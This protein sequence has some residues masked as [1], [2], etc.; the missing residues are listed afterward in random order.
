MYIYKTT[1]VKR[2]IPYSSKFSWHNIFVNFVIWLLIT[3]IF[4]TKI[5]YFHCGRGNVYAHAHHDCSIHALIRTRS[6]SVERCLKLCMPTFKKT[7][8]RCLSDPQEPLSKQLPSSLIESANNNVQVQFSLLS[9]ECEE[10][11]SSFEYQNTYSS[12]LSYSF[13]KRRRLLAFHHGLGARRM[14]L[15]IAHSLS[16]PFAVT[17]VVLLP[18]VEGVR[19]ILPWK[20]CILQTIGVIQCTPHC[21]SSIVI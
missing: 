15:H 20:K 3:K 2:K 11:T 18:T 13:G 7:S 8:K 1:C 19:R 6:G 21:L 4:F 10:R 12:D 14:L 5:I 16:T 9:S 17:S